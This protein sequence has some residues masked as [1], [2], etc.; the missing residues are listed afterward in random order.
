MSQAE[1]IRS[2]PYTKYYTD[3]E[4]SRMCLEYASLLEQGKGDSEEADALLNEIPL[5]P[6]GGEVMKK[7]VGIDY[8]IE[9][10][11]NLYEVIQEYG[12]GWIE[13]K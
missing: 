9:S 12:H 7:V 6:K 5:L 1:A 8:M 10:R 2:E 11:M 3:E 4:I 13:Q